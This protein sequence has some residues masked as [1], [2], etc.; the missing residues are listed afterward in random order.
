MVSQNGSVTVDG[1]REGTH[2]ISLT[3]MTGNCTVVGGARSVT[4]SAR[5]AVVEVAFSVTC[6]ALG[7]VEVTVATAGTHPDPTGYTVV[8]HAAEGASFGAQSVAANGTVAIPQLVPG[9]NWIWLEG[10]AGNCGG[11]GGVPRPIDVPSGGTAITTFVVECNEPTR[12]VYVGAREAGNTE[13]FSVRSDGTDAVALTTHVGRDE[14]PD[15]SPDGSRIAFASDRDGPLGVYLMNADGSDVRRLTPTSLVSYRPAWS[16]DGK[17]IAFVA[18]M[19]QSTDIY[20]IDTTGTNQVRLTTDP[21]ADTD[22]AWS[23]DGTRIAFTNDRTGSTD[24]YVMNADGSGVSQITTAD[25]WDG[26]PAWSP[27]GGTIALARKTCRTDWFSYS[28]CYQAVVVADA[29]G[30]SLAEVGFGEDPQWSRDGSRIAVTGFTC[31]FVSLYGDPC[32]SSGIAFLLPFRV[33]P[34]GYVDTWNPRITS[35]TH[36]NPAWR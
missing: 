12:L 25:W 1:I 17:R 34:L 4:I 28:Y 16:P 30:G 7:S 8:V 32:H 23:P 29:S 35:G 3:G 36:S 31:D 14:D 5:N 20:V 27:D 24:I 11:S 2:S 21:A 33:A 18:R 26:Q 15:W 19:G 6:D 10:L 13:I 9:R 22:P